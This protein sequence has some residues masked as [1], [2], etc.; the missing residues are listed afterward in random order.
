M[1]KKE[2]LHK[3]WEF[4]ISPEDA[5]EHPDCSNWLPA[6]VPGTVHTD[7]LAAGR[8]PDPFYGDN[9]KYLRWVADAGWSYR[10]KF[11]LPDPFDPDRSVFLVCDGI[12][13]IAN[14]FLNGEKIGSA[15]NMFRR[16]RFDI[17]TQL[18]KTDNILEIKFESPTQ[19][20]RAMIRKYGDIFSVRWAERSYIRKA[21][22]SF[23]WDW[24]PAFP[25]M[26]IW[27]DIF[28]WQP[29][30]TWIESV[31]FDTVGLK[32]NRAEVQVRL[33]ISGAG[34]VRAKVALSRGDIRHA[35][36]ISCSGSGQFTG[37][38]KVDNPH[39]WWPNGSGEP[40]LYDLEISLTEENGQVSD[41]KNLTVGI[42]QIELVENNDGRPSFFFRINGKP[43]FMRGADWIPADSFIPR[44][45]PE[46]YENLLLAAHTA[47]INM[48][49]VWGGG[50]YELPLF[51]R[52]C[53]RLGILIWQDFM[54]AC[55]AYPEHDE[56]QENITGEIE[57]V[58]SEMQ[59]HPSIAIWCGNNENEWIWYR[60]NMGRFTEMPGYKIFH[61]L[62]PGLVRQLD[63]YRNYRPSSPFGDDDDPNDPASGNRHQWDI[64]SG[65]IDYEEVRKD[66]SLFVTEFGFQGPANPATFD[67]ILPESEKTPES[68]LF[69]FHNKQ[70]EGNERI[71][72]F[73]AGHLP[74]RTTW[75][76]FIYLAQLNQGLALKSCL[77]HWRGRWPATAGSIVWQLNDCW[78]VT[79]WSLIDSGLLPK[80]AYY[81]VKQAFEPVHV[82]IIRHQNDIEILIMNDT[83]SRFEGIL[84]IDFII[85]RTGISD[86][87]RKIQVRIDGGSVERFTGVINAQQSDPGD[88]C[89]VISLWDNNGA[90]I[91]R[92]FFLPGRWKF[93]KMAKAVINMRA[94]NNNDSAI[95]VLTA[96]RAAFFVDAVSENIRMEPRGFILLAGEEKQVSITTR[97]EDPANSLLVCLNDYLV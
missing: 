54:F 42:R 58:V 3:G 72:R 14:I 91:S 33:T 90:L 49:R 63:P 5:P 40:N 89:M 41:K 87:R 60:E 85:L 81:F 86:Y 56:F 24:G 66:V 68:L 18:K 35:Q 2:F 25:T 45:P 12:D 32:E 82:Q 94:L 53:D 1:V 65:W 15:D 9:E 20:G 95:C 19:Y 96:D 50:I 10:T 84:G 38:F 46:K 70:I 73:L 31:G 6:A 64:W 17:S 97:G 16:F 59:P 62:I 29:D 4:R 92:N 52:L 77:E 76:D 48:L 80:T 61:Q 67:G 78:P 74:V 36:T 75:L 43:V 57:H 37:G 34:D 88:R 39:L 28:L 26:G 55:A 83:R 51:Y 69:T 27:R 71:F 11:D 21:Q 47:N 44:I 13:T 7:L 93:Q 8:I 79:S 30:N 23:G 22:Y